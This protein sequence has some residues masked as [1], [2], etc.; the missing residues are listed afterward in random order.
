MSGGRSDEAAE[1]VEIVRDIRQ[2][3]EDPLLVI[4]GIRYYILC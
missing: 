4:D 3:D 1:D 2:L